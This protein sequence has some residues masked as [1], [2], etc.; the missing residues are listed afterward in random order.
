MKKAI[1]YFATCILIVSSVAAMPGSKTLKRFNETFP[2]AQNVKW[3]DDKAG[4]FVSFMQSGNFNKVFYNTDGNLVYALK[5]C[6]GSELPINIAMALN[7]QFGE[8]KILGVTE[9]TT[10]NNV[11]YNIKLSKEN[12]LYDLNLLADGSVTKQEVFDDGTIA[13]TAQ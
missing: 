6:T 13:A 1:L 3:M 12:K 2:N 11:M 8:S 5:Y 9:V 7:K 4:F 10:Q